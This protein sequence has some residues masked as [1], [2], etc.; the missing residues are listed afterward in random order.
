ML[1]IRLAGM[2]LITVASILFATRVAILQV[3][4]EAACTSQV[5]LPT[6]GLF[7]STTGADRKTGLSFCGS[8]DACVKKCLDARVLDIR[9]HFRRFLAR[10]SAA[11]ANVIFKPAAVRRSRVLVLAATSFDDMIALSGGNPL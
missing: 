4:N 8:R 11:A 2:S 7:Q 9:H 3:R 6:L 10:S 1:S 5:N